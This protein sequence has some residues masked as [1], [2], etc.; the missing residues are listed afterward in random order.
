MNST[1]L[2]FI[3]CFLIRFS[4]L[5]RNFLENIAYVEHVLYINFLDVLLVTRFISD[6]HSF[7]RVVII[8]IR[9]TRKRI[10]D[11]KRNKIY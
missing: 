8:F 10:A 2:Y 3:Y 4:R 11:R 6:L 5:I 1:Q 9:L 7:Y